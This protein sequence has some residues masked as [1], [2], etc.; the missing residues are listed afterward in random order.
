MLSVPVLDVV[1][2]GLDGDKLCQLADVDQ[3]EARGAGRMR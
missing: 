2:V 1:A 3:H